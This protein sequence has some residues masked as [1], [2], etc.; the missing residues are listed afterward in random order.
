MKVAYKAYVPVGHRMKE[1]YGITEKNYQGVVDYLDV[2]SSIRLSIHLQ[3]NR[4]GDLYDIKFTE[5]K[6]IDC[7]PPVDLLPLIDP[8]YL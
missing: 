8:R 3:Y 7:Q 5:L 6:R 2:L 1:V 4:S